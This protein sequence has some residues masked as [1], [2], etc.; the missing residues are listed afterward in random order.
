MIVKIIT[1]IQDALDRLVHQ[2]RNSPYLG[3]LIEALVQEKQ[4]LEDAFCS[5]QENR[6]PSAAEGAVLDRIADL[7]GVTRMPGDTDDVLRLA[8]QAGISRNV[9]EGEPERVLATF[10]LLVDQQFV[11][12]H[13]CFPGGIILGSAH[14]FADQNEVNEIL[15]VVESILPAGVRVEYI[16]TFDETEPFAF[17]GNLN[18]SGF[19][20]VADPAAG[21]VFAK[22]VQRNGFFSFDGNISGTNEGFGTVQDSLV[23]GLFDGL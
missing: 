5:I 13:E 19:G 8:I 4:N 21:G 16:T 20:S 22:R 7:V 6:P 15:N 17:D 18:G 11:L 3:F 2:Y 9:A 23:G 10:R 1:H 14:H 12:I